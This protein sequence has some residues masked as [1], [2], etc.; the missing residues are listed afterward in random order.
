MSANANSRGFVAA[1]GIAHAGKS[2]FWHASELLFAYYLTEACGLPP[3]EMG[4]IV[5]ASLAL[6]ALADLVAGLTLRHRV[7]SVMSAGKAQ[8]QGAV[9]SG[10]A[11]AA[12]GLSSFVPQ[13]L[14]RLAFASCTLIAFRLTY[15]LLD[16][17]QNALLSLATSDDTQGA[18]LTSVR[19]VFGGVANIIVAA[20]FA[21]LFGSGG[22]AAMSSGFALFAILVALV[23]VVSSYYLWR[24]LQHFQ[25]SPPPNS[26]ATLTS[27]HSP[28]PAPYRVWPAGVMLFFVSLAM[29]VFSRLEPYLAAYGMR[30]LLQGGVLLTCV[31]A[32][33]LVSQ[34]FW[35]RHAAGSSLLTTL[36]WSTVWLAAAAAVFGIL[37][38][39]GPVGAALGGSLYGWGCGGVLMSLWAVAAAAGQGNSSPTTIFGALTCSSKIALALAAAGV[40]E[41]LNATPY[42]THT[43]AVA[44]I[45]PCMIVVPIVASLATL[46]LSS[47]VR[48]S[49]ALIDNV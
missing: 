17:P 47:Y 5:G 32:G 42:R 43:A 31:A 6:S 18:R 35:A 13:G 15:A 24:Y 39:L 45:L 10:A 14:T 8:L 11:F 30:S 19:Y 4:L 3:R 1:Y 26:E 37:C 36:R 46:V 7:S 29:S 12:F 25:E 28:Q 27:H 38:N 48:A 33:N 9:L 22:V 40:A 16:N 41:V 23:G 34:P 21:P 2:L 20:T 44:W 49:P